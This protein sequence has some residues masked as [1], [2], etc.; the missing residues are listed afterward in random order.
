MQVFIADNPTT[1]E[2]ARVGLLVL[3]DDS[4]LCKSEYHQSD[5]QCACTIVESGENYC[6]NRNATCREL[7][8]A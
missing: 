7:V 1:V 5:G 4:L 6:G 8:I 2:K 3:D